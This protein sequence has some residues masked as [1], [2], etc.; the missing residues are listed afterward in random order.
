M[1]KRIKKMNRFLLCLIAFLLS[2][3]MHGLSVIKAEESQIP[4]GQT[5]C[6]E[7]ETTHSEVIIEEIQQDMMLNQEEISTDNESEEKVTIQD[8]QLNQTRD[9][10]SSNEIITQN[11]DLLEKA[12]AVS[13]DA[14]G[15]LEEPKITTSQPEADLQDNPV[16]NVAE[17]QV[18]A[19]FLFEKNQ[20]RWYENGKIL[21]RT[22]LVYGTKDNITTWYYIA[23]G[24]F[25]ESTGL[26]KKID[27]NDTAYY[28][29]ENG[30]LTTNTLF[31]KIV[32][33]NSGVYR[34]VID[35]KVCDWTGMVL[36]EID[37]VQNLYYIRN[38]TFTKATGITKY[39]DGRDKKL[40]YVED[41]VFAKTTK[42]AYMLDEK[43]A[44]TPYYIKDGKLYQKTGLVK[45][46]ISG[47]T[48][49][50]YITN[51]M[52][53]QKASGLSRKA[54]TSQDNGW[55][56]VQNGRWSKQTGFT[57]RIDKATNH[58]YYVKNGKYTKSTL[59]A[60]KLNSTDTGWYYA[61][62]GRVVTGSGIV[63]S[64]LFDKLAWYYVYHG[65]YDSSATGITK[66]LDH[67]SDNNWYY[68]YR[69][70]YKKS[71]GLTQKTNSTDKTWYYVYKGK[72]TRKTLLSK[73]LNISASPSFYVVK[74]KVFTASKE[75]WLK[76]NGKTYYLQKNQSA[77]TGWKKINKKWYY[78]D[79]DGTMVTGWKYF[80]QDWHFFKPNGVNV[81]VASGK[82]FGTLYI[83]CVEIQLPL[84]V[85]Y[86]GK[87]QSIVDKNN[88][89]AL[90]PKSDVPLIADHRSQTF[91]KLPKVSVGTTA[92]IIGSDGTKYNYKCIECGYGK[93]NGS[94]LYDEK[95]IERTY[96]KCSIGT[97]T[98][99]GWPN[100]FYAK[101]KMY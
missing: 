5:F 30:V 3:S 11:T 26:V 87:S 19:G 89:G 33:S 82:Y 84:Y 16:E 97:Y 31:A 47:N 65:R 72:Y 48:D 93:S 22:G 91:S 55:Y 79:T 20:W 53:D 34:Y 28:Y 83:P 59:F 43:N 71:T 96:W 99:N 13:E 49:W 70:T 18:A 35:G 51:G 36:D 62:S 61:K 1:Q 95:G 9:E 38:G 88:S 77:Y 2:I 57:Q 27:S 39:A 90:L 78:F 14:I 74:G 67:S 21:R 42:F 58:W 56:Y 6:A 94:N 41:G 80:D 73:K 24:V 60:K 46:T 12:T 63:R 44:I 45:G 92:Y 76:L 100:V 32:G 8:E 40:Y 66:K 86:N 23:N 50:Y 68:V 52:Y 64:I 17:E 54:D 15:I 75:R 101:W 69:G 29:V 85:G 25:R 4:E 98:C 10:G 37:G 7:S 81:S